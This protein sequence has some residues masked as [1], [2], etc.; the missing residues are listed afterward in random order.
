MR[1]HFPRGESYDVDMVWGDG[2]AAA[3]IKMSRYAMQVGVPL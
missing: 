3:I 1:I 2:L